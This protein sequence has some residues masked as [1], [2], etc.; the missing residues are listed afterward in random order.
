[1]GE[2][3]KK[4]ISPQK[5]DLALQECLICELNFH[6]SPFPSFKQVIMS[7]QRK[8]EGVPSAPAGAAKAFAP[9]PVLETV[10]RKTHLICVASGQADGD[11][12]SPTLCVAVENTETGDKFS[13][14]PHVVASSHSS[15]LNSSLVFLLHDDAQTFFR[16]DLEE[17]VPEKLRAGGDVEE[18]ADLEFLLVECL[19]A[20][21]LGAGASLGADSPTPEFFSQ[22]QV[23]T[24]VCGHACVRACAMSVRAMCV[25]VRARVRV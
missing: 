9:K 3:K 16:G 20:E 7:G 23:C 21:C 15:H 14:V 6:C 13:K 24:C 5:R 8:C 1:V 17:I 10:L 19:R 18:L 11:A 25:C 2:R 22:S 12:K 4:T